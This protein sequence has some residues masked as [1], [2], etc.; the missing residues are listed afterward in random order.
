M[1]FHE[2]RLNPDISYRSVGGPGYMTD[3]IELSS[4]AEQAVARWNGERRSY[5]LVQAVKS[6]SELSEIYRFYLGRRGVANGFRLKDWLD[7]ASTEDGRTTAFMGTADVTAT[8][9]LIGTGDGTTVQFQLKKYYASGNELRT[10]IIEKPVAGTIRIALDGVEQLTGWSANTTT[11]V[12][13]FTSPPATG[14]EVT[15]GFEFDVPVRF[16]K[17]FDR[18][19]P[20]RIEDFSHGSLDSIPLVELINPSQDADEFWYGGSTTFD[21]MAASQTLS[22]GLGRAIILKNVSAGLAIN[23]PDPAGL[24]L[25]GGPYWYIINEGAE[26]IIVNDETLTQIAT[27]AAGEHATVVMGVEA[28]NTTR[29]WYIL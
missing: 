2:V 22:L 12:I 9:V 14:V 15:A 29:V 27:I 11:G 21:P 8:D 24:P 7:Y 25:G 6:Y 20:V 17:E 4:G 16:G 26:S 10:R 19:L 3:L 28:D 23:L 5:D 13:T 1:G 18:Q